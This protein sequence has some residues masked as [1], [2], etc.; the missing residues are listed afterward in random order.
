M[1]CGGIFAASKHMI[2]SGILGDIRQQLV[3]LTPHFNNGC[4]HWVGPRWWITRHLLDTAFTTIAGSEGIFICSSQ[5]S[6]KEV[7]VVAFSMSL[8]TMGLFV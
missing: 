1:R 2:G 5:F 8:R 3:L 7:D 6:I 4:D